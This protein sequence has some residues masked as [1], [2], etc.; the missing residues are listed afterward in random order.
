MMISVVH[1][2]YVC[3]AYNLNRE[4][5][6]CYFAT[7]FTVKVVLISVSES[8][9]TDTTVTWDLRVILIEADEPYWLCRWYW[10]SGSATEI[11]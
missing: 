3:I 11:M 10:P 5:A 9:L 8:L 7:E 6:N 4:P 2:I 1:G